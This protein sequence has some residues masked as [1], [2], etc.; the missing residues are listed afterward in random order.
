MHGVSQAG[1]RSPPCHMLLKSVVVCIVA[2]PMYFVATEEEQG[3][4]GSS[5][6]H[7]CVILPS[8]DAELLGRLQPIASHGQ[9]NLATVNPNSIADVLLPAVMPH[10]QR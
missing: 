7:V 4:F 3:L 10:R 6:A 8:K 1:A 9:L 5:L 2:G